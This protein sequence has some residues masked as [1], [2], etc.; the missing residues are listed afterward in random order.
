MVLRC[1][2]LRIKNG[3]DLQL[4]ISSC[5]LFVNKQRVQINSRFSQTTARLFKVVARE[6]ETTRDNKSVR[7]VK[8]AVIYGASG[9][10]VRRLCHL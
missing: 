9:F 4:C 10:Y 5:E 7:S 6:C 2:I 1:V 3:I 8:D